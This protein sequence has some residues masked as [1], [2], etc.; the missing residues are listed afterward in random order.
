MLHTHTVVQDAA[1]LIIVFDINKN[2][3]ILNYLSHMQVAGQTNILI[4]M[5]FNK[6]FLEAVNLGSG[7]KVLS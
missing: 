7:F 5:N 6:Y 1:N 2:S 4:F 3:Y